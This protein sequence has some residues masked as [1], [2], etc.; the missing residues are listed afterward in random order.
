MHLQAVLLEPNSDI[1]HRLDFGL[2]KYLGMDIDYE[3]AFRNMGLWSLDNKICRLQ[4]ESGCTYVFLPLPG[5]ALFQT[6]LIGPY[7]TFEMSSQGVMEIAERLGIPAWRSSQ[8]EEYYK[9]VTLVQ[10]EMPLTAMLTSFGEV[11]WGNATDFEVVDLTADLFEI[12]KVMPPESENHSTDDLML[13]MKLMETRYGY[14]NELMEMV[15]QGQVHRAESMVTGLLPKD[16]DQRVSDTLRNR[17]NYMII[18]NTLMRKAAEWG[19]VHPIHLDSI[20]TEF[21]RRIEN[22]P[23]TDKAQR[24]LVDMVRGYSQVVRAHSM[25]NHSPIVQKAM[26]CIASGLANDLSLSALAGALNVNASYLSTLFRK[27]TGQTVTDYVNAM[28]MQAG[29]NLLKTTQLQVQ[30]IAQHCGI[31]DVNYFSKRF[32]KYYGIT[33]KQYRQEMQPLNQKKQSGAKSGN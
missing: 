9:N 11:L 30:S 17:K 26:I 19:G 12:S 32:K 14:E 4:D 2:R 20:S 10:N 1:N 24:L 3:R 13:R 27:E 5:T 31:S 29:A 7:I 15:A 21:A 8:L 22:M 16:F 28:R 25:K 18:S 6:L 23:S 33:P